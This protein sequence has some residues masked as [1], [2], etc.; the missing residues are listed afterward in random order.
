VCAHA[1]GQVWSAF[2]VRVHPGGRIVDP[3][4]KPAAASSS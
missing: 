2:F 3:V 1:R 4:E